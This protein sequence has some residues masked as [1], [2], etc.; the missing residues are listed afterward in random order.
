MKKIKRKIGGLVGKGKT[1]QG[2]AQGKS[3]A[4]PAAAALSATGSIVNGLGT[5]VPGFGILG[6][7]LK[8]GSSILNPDVKLKDLKRTEEAVTEG[9][10]LICENIGKVKKEVETRF[11]NL[12]LEMETLNSEVIKMKNLLDEIYS[13]INDI[14]YKVSIPA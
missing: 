14:H 12:A 3:W 5:F 13:T 1:F 10:Q 2:K 6:G 11:E 4:E 8:L 9:Q 7:A